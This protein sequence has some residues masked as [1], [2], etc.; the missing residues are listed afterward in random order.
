MTMFK[1]AV[2]HRVPLRIG[3]LGPP[4]SGKT[5]TA[6]QLAKH[7]G[8]KKIAVLDTERGSASLY[9]NVVPF[10]TCELESF[11][12]QKYLDAIDFAAKHGYDALIIDSLSHA[13]A[14]KGGMLE[15][16]DAVAKRQRNPNSYTAWREATPLHNQLV[17]AMLGYPG[18]VLATMRTKVE[19]VLEE[20]GRGKK[21]PRKIGLAPVQREGL[22]Y[23]FSIVME[24]DHENTGV[25]T[26]TRCSALRNAVIPMP[27]RQMAETILAWLN[28]G[29]PAEPAAPAAPAAPAE[30]TPAQ[31]QLAEMVRVARERADQ[32][33][34]T[35]SRERV[36]L[37]LQGRSPDAVPDADAEAL[38]GKTGAMRALCL[39]LRSRL[40]QRAAGPAP[41]PAPAPSRPAPEIAQLAEKVRRRRAAFDRDRPDLVDAADSLLADYCPQGRRL[42]D[43]SAADLDALAGALASL[44]TSRSAA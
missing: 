14:G 30:P 36:A 6:L 9:S 2:K 28:D 17:D 27:G 23:E 25:V 20:D 42:E 15:F 22:D 7:L 31:R 4:G 16:V 19:Y 43:L 13:W 18:H 5:Y 29:A 37:L 41:D 12:V 1:P 34:D 3:L 39:D 33:G 21:V 40:E 26:K 35:A 38:T 11:E 24:M 8:A 10:D 44:F 32:L